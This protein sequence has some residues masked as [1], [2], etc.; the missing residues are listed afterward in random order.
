M[1]TQSTND[2]DVKIYMDFSLDYDG[3]LEN[4]DRVEKN[5][6]DVTD[7]VSY[8]DLTPFVEKMK[9]LDGFIVSEHRTQVQVFVFEDDMDIE[10][11][12]YNEPEDGEFDEYS[13]TNVP[14][15][16]ELKV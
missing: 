11:R 14:L 9:E 4:I 5:G 13:L 8:P 3:Q 6:V 16:D 12:C 1:T 10:F 7:K 2:L 15:V